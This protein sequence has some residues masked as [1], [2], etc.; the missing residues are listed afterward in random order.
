[1]DL[2]VLLAVSASAIAAPPTGPNSL[3]VRL[4]KEGRKMVKVSHKIIKIHDHSLLL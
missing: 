1:M 2:S 4:E 3:K